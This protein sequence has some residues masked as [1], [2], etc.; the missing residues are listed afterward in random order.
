MADFSALKTSIQNYIKQNGNEEI[1]GNLLQQILLSMVTTL[2]DS[3]INDLVTAL[4]AEIANR[5][6][7]DTELGGRI[8]T[9]QG[10]VNG[11]KSN[12]ENGYVYAGIATPSSTPASGKVFYLALTAGTY[13]NFGETVV[14]QGI[15]I[16][17]YNGSAWS[18]ESFIGVDDEPTAGSN[19]L[20]KS[21][22]VYEEISQLEQKLHLHY[23]TGINSGH[24]HFNLNGNN[25]LTISMDPSVYFLFCKEFYAPINPSEDGGDINIFN[26]RINIIYFHNHNFFNTDNYENIP[27]N[28]IILQCFFYQSN[29]FSV[30]GFDS[31]LID[32]NY[33]RPSSRTDSLENCNAAE[34]VYWPLL[35]SKFLKKEDSNPK[36]VTAIFNGTATATLK[37]NS[38]N[39]H[40]YININVSTSSTFAYTLDGYYLLPGGD[41]FLDLGEGEQILYI[42]YFD[43]INNIFKISNSV[44]NLDATNIVLEVFY[45][46]IEGLDKPYIWGYTTPS[47]IKEGFTNSSALN[48]AGLIPS[49]NTILDNN[50]NYK[51]ATILF[52]SI[53]MT[54]R[55]DTENSKF[56]V[57]IAY[58]DLAFI[59][60]PASYHPGPSPSTG[61]VS[62]EINTL[63]CIIYYDTE[64]STFKITSS[65]DDLKHTSILLETWY[66]A[67][68]FSFEGVQSYYAY[69]TPIITKNN[70]KSSINGAKSLVSINDIKNIDIDKGFVFPYSAKIFMRVG[71]VGDSYT[72][73]HI[74]I[75]SGTTISNPNYAWPHYMKSKTG[76]IWDNYGKSGSTTRTWV[77]KTPSYSDLDIMEQ[78][79]Q[80]CQA[81]IIGLGLNDHRQDSWGVPV[82]VNTDIG[83]DN[84]TYYAWYYKLI[85]ALLN[86]NNEAI[87]FCNTCPAYAENEA[88]NVAVRE[89]VTYCQ[90][91]SQRVHCIDLAN[92]INRNYYQDEIFRGDAIGGHYT[93]IGYEYM[94]EVYYKVLSDYINSHIS[95]FQDVHLIDYDIP[96]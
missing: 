48:K 24:L 33:P 7:A 94:A 72:S 15:N 44:G 59:Y 62:L 91:N 1:T 63:M 8:T 9:L 46:L 21:G 92:S 50:G 36:I 68:L 18:L 2:G 56:Y 77:N 4:N 13:T 32:C 16:L 23:L 57:D 73:G 76:S 38:E 79:G 31:L 47:L 70:F 85:Q 74:Q 34:Y 88:Y 93:A 58:T 11:I 49:I 25:I 35:Y 28:S 95:Q 90:N 30:F 65:W 22:G 6:N 67:Y 17:K 14:P 42:L 87:I 54:L 96:N 37:K 55:E 78:P 84:D 39:N 45:G 66:N 64:S 81:Y 52:G 27:Y 86:I 5:G 75:S 29:Q 69:T 26:G 61:S 71:C 40:Y 10:V 53:S 83:T 43:T 20:V 41:S 51:I 60:T 89:V 3:A 12:V 82:G 80:K 19:N